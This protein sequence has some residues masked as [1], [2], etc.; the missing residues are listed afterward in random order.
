VSSPCVPTAVPW[1]GPPFPPPGPRGTSSPTSTVRRRAPTPANPSRRAHG[2]ARRYPCCAGRFAPPRPDAAVAARGFSVRQ[3]L[4]PIR[5]TR[6]GGRSLRL[7]GNPGGRSPCSRTPAGLR[8]QACDSPGARPLRTFEA[9]GSR[10]VTGSRGSRARPSPWRSPPRR[11]GRPGRRKTRF[12]P[13][14]RL[15]RVGLVTHR[16]PTKGFRYASSFPNLSGR[17]ERHSSPAGSR[18]RH[19]ANAQPCL[20]WPVRCSGLFGDGVCLSSIPGPLFRSPLP[21]HLTFECAERL[22]AVH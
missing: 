7:L 18:G 12:R 3:P 11:S 13:L 1:P 6:E 17:N 20:A 4:R 2:L 16:V 8:G 19:C 10:R 9:V 22:R 14:A 5:R 21:P 15:Y